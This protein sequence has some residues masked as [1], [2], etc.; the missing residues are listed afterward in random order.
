M[1]LV[2]A[3]GAGKTTLFAAG[4]V[5]ADGEHEG[6]VRQIRGRQSCGVRTLIG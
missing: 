6:G 3:N 4:P 1:G 5:P 2:R